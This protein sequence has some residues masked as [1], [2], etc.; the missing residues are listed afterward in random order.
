MTSAEANETV[1]INRQVKAHLDAADREMMVA[2]TVKSSAELW[3][4]A[5]L[6]AVI[7]LEKRGLPHSSDQEIMESIK[8]VDHSEGAEGKFVRKYLAVR[9]FHHNAENDYME[10]DDFLFCRPGV[11]EFVDQMQE[12]FDKTR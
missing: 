10:L 2:D 4:A 9:R 7:T 6:A 12:L 8:A 5:R 3:V 11:T 1:E